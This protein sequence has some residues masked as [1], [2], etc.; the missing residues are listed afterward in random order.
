MSAAKTAGAALA[1]KTAEG[2]AKAKPVAE[3]LVERAKPKLEEAARR[4]VEK[5]AQG[6]MGA[7]QIA[8]DVA[9]VVQEGL[10]S[11]Q[12]RVTP[13]VREIGQRVGEGMGEIIAHPATQTGV[14][15]AKKTGVKLIQQAVAGPNP[16]AASQV[17]S[18]AVLAAVDA[19]VDP[20]KRKVEDGEEQPAKR[21]R[22]ET[23][24]QVAPVVEET[25]DAMDSE[26]E[27][28]IQVVRRPKKIKK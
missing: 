17:L 3:Q 15:A 16:D 25:P 23:P 12:E 5:T 24:E 21:M 14:E 19:L 28:E 10:Q 18:A 26:E 2:L 9:P 8:S 4:T 20:R 6:L 7:K 11:V 22:Q 1:A 27:D 13:V